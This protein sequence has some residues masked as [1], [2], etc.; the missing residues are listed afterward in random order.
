MNRV[1]AR[2]EHAVAE[3]VNGKQMFE[4]TFRGSPLFLQACH[5][6][7]AHVNRKARKLTGRKYEPDWSQYGLHDIN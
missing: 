6:I 3:H 2:I 7:T 1:R 4:N 5:I